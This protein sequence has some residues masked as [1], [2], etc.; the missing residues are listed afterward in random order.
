MFFSL[1]LYSCSS[2]NFKRVIENDQFDLLSNE[3]FM[4]Y[5]SGRLTLKEDKNDNSLSLALVACHQEKFTKGLGIL[6]SNMH[7]NKNNPYYWNALGN[8][9]YLKG[10]TSKAVF[11]YQLGLESLKTSKE[12]IVLAES[13]I[14]NNMGLIHLKNGRFNQ[15]FDMFTKSNKLTP[16]LFTPKFNMAQLY[17]EFNNNKEALKILKELE[18]NNPLDIDLLYSFSLV[19]YRENKLDLSFNYIN[20]VNKDYL[21]HPDIVG[22]YAYNLMNKDKLVDA[23]KILERRLHSRIYDE[24][25]EMI[26]GIV[27]DKLKE[28]QSKAKETSP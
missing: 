18:I 21:N 23:K 11:Y 17:L 5:N 3:S 7:A 15:A 27:N 6:E 22:L 8:C 14:L 1:F 9:Y 12:N 10:E 28:Q 13:I 24:R 20:K 19:Y 4:R 16:Q 26:L 25:N 2:A